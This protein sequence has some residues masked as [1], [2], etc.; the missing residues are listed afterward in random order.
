M[1]YSQ[2]KGI[3]RIME[4][5][6]ERKWTI[7]GQLMLYRGYWINISQIVDGHEF[8]LGNILGTIPNYQRTRIGLL[9]RLV[10]TV[11]HA[12][13]L[14]AYGTSSLLITGLINLLIIGITYIDSNR[15]VTHRANQF[16]V[17]YYIA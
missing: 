11:A 13:L 9:V 8:L 2:D 5:Q 15:G 16:F 4:N 12:N 14:K 17:S 10:L 3:V 6:M 1:S 7:K